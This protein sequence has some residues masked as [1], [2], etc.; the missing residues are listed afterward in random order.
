MKL[1]WIGAFVVALLVAG[2]SGCASVFVRVWTWNGPPSTEQKVKALAFDVVTMPVQLPACLVCGR[3]CQL[4]PTQEVNSI[5]WWM[6]AY[7]E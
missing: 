2:L 3:Y 5:S 7:L 1:S 4:R 6:S